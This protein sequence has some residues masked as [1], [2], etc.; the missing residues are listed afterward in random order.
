VSYL[1]CLPACIYFVIFFNKYILV[2]Q[3]NHQLRPVETGCDRSTLSMCS[4]QPQ[5]VVYQLGARLNRK[6]SCFRLWS[7]PVPVFFQF[8]QLDLQSLS[9]SL[10]LLTGPPHLRGCVVLILVVVCV[11]PHPCRACRVAW[12][13]SQYS[14][15]FSY[16]TGQP[17]VT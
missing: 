14:H 6:S 1:I 12:T 3:E 2:D 7:G 11:R 5:P 9:S 4:E 13:H 10:W 17:K 8:P 15:Y 16:Y